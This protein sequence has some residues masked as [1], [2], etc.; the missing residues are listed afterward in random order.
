MGLK[1]P[2]SVPPSRGDRGGWRL[3][4]STTLAYI[5]RFPESLELQ[6]SFERS[7]PGCLGVCLYT[8]CVAELTTYSDRLKSSQAENI[9]AII[10]NEFGERS[11]SFVTPDNYFWTLLEA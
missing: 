1:P 2:P 6:S 8:Y 5:I 7:Q 11:L 3:Y 4:I 9:T 10:S